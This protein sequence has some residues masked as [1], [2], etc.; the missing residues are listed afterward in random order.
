MLLPLSLINWVIKKLKK[1]K[2]G[3]FTYIPSQEFQRE[4]TLPEWRLL[5]WHSGQNHSSTGT[6]SRGGVRHSIWYLWSKIKKYA[7][8]QCALPSC[9]LTDFCSNCC[10]GF[11]FLCCYLRRV[12]VGWKRKRPQ[13][14]QAQIRTKITIHQD[15]C[16]FSSLYIIPLLV[17]RNFCVASDSN[18][19][20]SCCVLTVPTTAW[21]DGQ[22]Q[23]NGQGR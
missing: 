15:I 12:Q 23:T 21:T 4:P 9:S 6:E 2:L 8:H 13:Q 1:N 11:S 19:W 7:S 14:A 22:M 18:P 16:W 5:A 20:S 10:I 17:H 3:T